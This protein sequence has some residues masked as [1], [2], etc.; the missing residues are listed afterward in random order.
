MEKVGDVCAHSTSIV[1]AFTWRFIA[2]SITTILVLIVS[3]ELHMAAKVGVADVVTKLIAYY[4][5]ERGW[6]KYGDR[7]QILTVLYCGLSDRIG[8]LF[9]GIGKLFGKLKDRIAKLFG[10]RKS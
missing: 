6:L 3:G 1:K 10:R 7:L 4:L 8:K 2:T 5:H 9:S